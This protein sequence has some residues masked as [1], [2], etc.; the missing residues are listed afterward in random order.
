[1]VK[2]YSTSSVYLD[3]VIKNNENPMIKNIEKPIFNL[4][5]EK[6]KN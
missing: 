2:N 4:N 5:I 3:P 6:I 1:M